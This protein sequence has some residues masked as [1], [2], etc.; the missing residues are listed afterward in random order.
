MPGTDPARSRRRTAPRRARTPCTVL[1]GR[2][3]GLRGGGGEQEREQRHEAPQRGRHP[4]GAGVEAEREIKTPTRAISSVFRRPRRALGSRL[5]PRGR[6]AGE[7]RRLR[8]YSLAAARPHGSAAPG[9]T[10]AAAA[11]LRERRRA[12]ARLGNA[13][14]SHAASRYRRS[15]R[16]GKETYPDG[17]RRLSLAAAPHAARLQGPRAQSRPPPGG[18]PRRLHAPRDETGCAPCAGATAAPRPIRPPPA[19]SAARPPRRRHPRPP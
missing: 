3:A 5:G 11:R 10:P 12:A 19:G 8:C 15:S 1:T 18:G 9:R 13:L 4:G 14:I 17:K 6:T 7:G 2:S 16:V